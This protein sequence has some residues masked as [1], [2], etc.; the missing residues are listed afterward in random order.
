MMLKALGRNGVCGR[1]QGSAGECQS[2]ISLPSC[3]LPGDV[4]IWQSDSVC[5]KTLF[6]SF[7]LNGLDPSRGQCSPKQDAGEKYHAQDPECACRSKGMREP[8]SLAGIGQKPL[9][10]DQSNQRQNQNGSTNQL[11]FGNMKRHQVSVL[12][13]G[14][15]CSA[16]AVR[17]ES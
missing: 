9:F 3:F 11:M 1:K 10:F 15:V 7:P 2:G 14:S 16:V 5:V 12:V 6:A 13:Y 8:L 4:P 17:T